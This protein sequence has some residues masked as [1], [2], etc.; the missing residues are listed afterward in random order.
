MYDTVGYTLVSSGNI[1]D[2][3]ARCLSSKRH[4]AETNLCYYE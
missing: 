3:F 1:V 2:D 4:D